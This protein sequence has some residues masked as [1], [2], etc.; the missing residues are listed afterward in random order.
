M[1][2]LF[3][4]SRRGESLGWRRELELEGGELLETSQHFLIVFQPWD[5]RIVHKMSLFSVFLMAKKF[6]DFGTKTMT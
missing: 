4:F 6:L 5:V 1:V 2:R 3:Y